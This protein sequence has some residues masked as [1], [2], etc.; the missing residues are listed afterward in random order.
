MLNYGE[1]KAGK[2]IVLDNQPYQV[3]EAS[4]LR[5]Q[6]RRPVMQTKLKNLATDKTVE[7][8]F[9]QSDKIKEAEIMTKEIKYL[10]SHRGEFWFSEKDDSSK[11]FE[12]EEVLVADYADLMKPNAT[13]E[14]IVFNDK[15]IGIKLPI[16]LD[17][18]VTEAPP[19][20]RG[21]TAQGGVKQIKL[22]TG[23]TI[24]APL[25]ISEGDIVRI[26]T[27]T[28]EYVERVEKR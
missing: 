11:R 10:Y 25:F 28:K 26:N 7:K 9:Q 27:E 4:F 15:I 20:I 17:L 2:Y 14:A 22:E 23:A 24:T 21:D 18:K 8:T 16:K 6:Q 13:V 19:A 3:M 5:M 12:I 1:L